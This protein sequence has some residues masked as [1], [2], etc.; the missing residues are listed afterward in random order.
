MCV[1]LRVGVRL[2]NLRADTMSDLH[3]ADVW[4]CSASGICSRL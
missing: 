3:P 4:L 2:R 1:T